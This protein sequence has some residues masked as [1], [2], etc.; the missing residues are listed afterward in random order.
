MEKMK[1]QIQEKCLYRQP[2]FCTAVCPF[3]LDVPDFIEKMQR[4]SFSSAYRV[5]RNA[6]VFPGIVSRLCDAPCVPVCPREQSDDPVAL[7]M[8]ER[9]AVAYAPNRQPNSYNIPQKPQRMAVIGAGISGLTCAL[10]LASRNFDVTVYEKS[11]R[12]GGQLWEQL[13][14]QLFLEEIRREFSAVRYCLRLSTEITSLDGLKADAVYVA[15]GAAGNCF[16]LSLQQD[17]TAENPKGVFPGGALCGSGSVQA[18]ADGLHAAMLMEQYVLAGTITEPPARCGAQYTLEADRFV[19]MPM[20]VPRGGADYSRDE[21]IAEAK[22]C[23]RCSCDLCQRHCDLMSYYKQLPPRIAADV[24]STIHPSGV[25]GKETFAKRLMASCTHCGSCRD[26]CPVSLDL[27]ELLLE[28]CR[29]MRRDGKLPW[30]FHEFWLRDMEHAMGISHLARSPK[31][32]QT[33]PLA[34]FPGCQ[35]GASD[36]D[37]VLESY[38]WILEQYGDTALWLSCCGVPAVW[39]GDDPLTGQALDALRTDWERLGRPEVVFACP[40]CKNT[41][42]Q[43]LPEIKGHFLFERMAESGFVPRRQLQG[44]SF[45]V[46]DPCTSRHELPMQQAVREL[47]RRAGVIPEALPAEG[48]NAR[49]CSWGGHISTANPPLAAK[50]TKTCIEQSGFPYI[51]YCANCRD[52]FADEG[53]PCIHLLDL[54]FDLND[55]SRPAPGCTERR[56]N[57]RILKQQALSQFWEEES[58][59]REDKENPLIIDEALRKKMSEDRILE[60]DAAAAVAYCE[61]SGRTV[62]DSETGCKTGYAVIGRLTYWVTYYREG[63]RLRL[64]NA[65]VHRMSINLEETWNGKRVGNDL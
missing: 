58:P 1:Q 40:T 24:Y 5:Y 53:K 2:A 9:A 43:R 34:F 62:I 41:F 13:E 39:A 14:P 11:D 42:A 47:T 26:A 30:T 32:V 12:I 44:M 25:F 33:S 51:T 59:L 18:I 38:R 37:Y 3:D 57:R 10:R 29:I 64:K 8:L 4:G 20:V 21:S 52:I 17:L 49:C 46:F 48:E 61:Q 23:L 50:Q 31:G 65:Y 45:S 16:G 27:G 60:E 55:A 28:G 15:T 7:P 19:Y 22:R 35:L 63:E 56:N 6:V 54:L 36:P